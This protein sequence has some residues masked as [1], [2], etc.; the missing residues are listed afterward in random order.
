M[1]NTFKIKPEITLSRVKLKVL[2]EKFPLC[3]FDISLLMFCEIFNFVKWI[4]ISSSSCFILKDLKQSTS[5]YK[6]IKNKLEILIPIYTHLYIYKKNTW[7]VRCFRRFTSWY[8]STLY[9]IFAQ[10]F[11]KRSC[12]LPHHWFRWQWRF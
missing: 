1:L 10:W 2:K 6:K 8:K 11:Y 3:V 12:N 4:Q 5:N 9:K 7:K